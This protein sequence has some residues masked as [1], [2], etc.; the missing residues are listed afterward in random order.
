MCLL[1]GCVW[2]HSGHR[3]SLVRSPQSRRCVQGGDKPG[4]WRLPP[5]GRVCARGSG[6]S[7]L[8][9]SSQGLGDMLAAPRV[10]SRR[11]PGSGTPAQEQGL[12]PWP[13]QP[14]SPLLAWLSW[15]LRSGTPQA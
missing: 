2:K 10:R 12:P 5:A 4:A 9:G 1:A 6:C 15:L 14:R 11:L 3:V 8:A 7:V 13:V